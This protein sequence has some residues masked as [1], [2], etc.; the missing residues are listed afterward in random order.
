ML[1]G[2]AGA[3]CASSAGEADSAAA[4]AAGAA[5]QVQPGANGPAAQQPQHEATAHA[6]GGGADA[7]ADAGGGS[8]RRQPHAAKQQRGVRLRGVGGSRVKQRDK[9]DKAPSRNK[10]CPCGSGRKHKVCCGAGRGGAAAGQ[11]QQQPSAA[12]EQLSVQLA[13][14]HI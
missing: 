3:S 2:G 9:A 13:T 6:H 4:S 12:T 5:E 10:A 8:G 7:D 11:Q 1:A 14:L